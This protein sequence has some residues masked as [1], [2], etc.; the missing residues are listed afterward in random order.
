MSGLR[1]AQIEESRIPDPRATDPVMVVNAAK[2][3]VRVTEVVRGARGTGGHR[4]GLMVEIILR[5]DCPVLSLHG[6]LGASSA[7]TLQSAMTAVL[8]THPRRVG[9]DASGVHEVE[10]AGAVLLLAM[11]RHARGHGS[12]LRIVNLGEVLSAELERLG[13]SDLLSDGDRV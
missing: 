5:Q 2:G 11:R 6:R 1:V 8:R 3:T 4:L 13:M 12:I 10:S 7:R 9:F